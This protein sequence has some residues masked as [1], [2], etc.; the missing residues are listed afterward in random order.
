MTEMRDAPMFPTNRAF[1]VQFAADADIARGA[2]VGR[3]EHV[4]SG[5]AAHFHALDGLLDFMARVLTETATA[6]EPFPAREGSDRSPSSP[7]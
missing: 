3:V 1:V 2:L 5:H 6:D 7:A 4:L